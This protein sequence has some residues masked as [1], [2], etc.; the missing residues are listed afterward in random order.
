[1]SYG[2]NISNT[3]SNFIATINAPMIIITTTNNNIG[4]NK[5]DDDTTNYDDHKG[6]N[7]LK[8][9][10][11]TDSLPHAGHR[12]YTQNFELNSSVTSRILTE[13]QSHR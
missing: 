13:S 10:E 6:I 11:S 2:N 1:M 3:L 7:N 5:T 4:N 9:S 8:D 12:Q